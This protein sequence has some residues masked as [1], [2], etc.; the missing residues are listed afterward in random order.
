LPRP[1]RTASPRPPRS[2]PGS[3]SARR[4]TAR[5]TPRAKGLRSVIHKRGVET[6]V[7]RWVPAQPNNTT[8]V[9]CAYPCSVGGMRAI[10]HVNNDAVPHLVLLRLLAFHRLD[11]FG[12]SVHA[13]ETT[14]AHP[15]P[16]VLCAQELLSFRA[17]AASIAV[18]QAV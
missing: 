15:H 3:D 8:P 7:R 5:A 18:W 2:P 9:V 11:I 12:Q 13:A 4:G 6:K 1:R 17:S 10:G 14:R 16:D